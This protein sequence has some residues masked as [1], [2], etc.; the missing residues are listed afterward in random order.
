[1]KRQFESFALGSGR[2]ADDPNKL[3]EDPKPVQAIAPNNAHN[4]D[5]Y[6][7]ITGDATSSKTNFNTW[8]DA[9]IKSFLD[10]R[11]ED[12]DDCHDFNAL[13]KRAEE[14]EINTG[15]AIKPSHQPSSDAATAAAPTHV[16]QEEDEEIDPL[17]AF[18]AK[19]ESI[20]AKNKPASKDHKE[21][22]QNTFPAAK[23]SRHSAAAERLEEE[24]HVADF[25]VRRQ[26]KFKGNS[27]APS[28]T[29]EPRLNNNTTV[30]SNR[31]PV[32]Y[33]SDEEVYAAARAVDAAAGVEIIDPGAKR[34]IQPLASANHSEI[35]Y[36]D[37]CKE[38]Y[39]PPPEIAALN[40]Q[41]VT[42][43]RRSL[44]V[45]VSGYGV[46]GPVDSFSQC[47]FDSL[48]EKSIL[49]AG[50]AVPTAIQAQALPVIL[51][52]RDVLGV[53]KT[54]SGKTAAFV[55]PLIVHVM[56]QR[57]LEQGE[58][59]IALIASPTRELAEQIHKETSKLIIS[60]TV[61]R[62]FR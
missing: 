16:N 14:C 27:T 17:D 3:Y 52:G 31:G 29:N 22:S 58:G 30:Q 42:E 28:V 6:D 10:L 20:E 38:F 25:L 23:R 9:E 39:E 51:S 26:Q 62:Q 18:M 48:L 1:M 35:D 44:G 50:Y 45:R 57:E 59:P 7:L 53:A 37:F 15:R 5:D 55:L 33:N 8:K 21:L 12:F 40:I 4:F 24:D 13:V 46:P 2:L 36:E 11:G 60:Y 61:I 19:I 56:D 49:K 47:G 32:D 34:I 54:G 41:E 43:K